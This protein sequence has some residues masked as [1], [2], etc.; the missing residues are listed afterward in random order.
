MKN[1][2]VK[3]VLPNGYKI[4]EVIN[5][6]KVYENKKFVVKE[7]KKYALADNNDPIILKDI[8]GNLVP[9][10]YFD[11]YKVD[12]EGN[13]IIGIKK[14]GKE[15]YDRVINQFDLSDTRCSSETD[16]D[17]IG[18]RVV[19]NTKH[20]SPTKKIDDIIPKEY[21]FNYGVINKEGLL[22]IYPIYDY[23]C[24]SNENTCIVG[25]LWVEEDLKYGYVDITTGDFITPIEFNE[26]RK[27]YDKRAVVGISA[28]SLKLSFGYVDRDKVITN[29]NNNNEY[30]KGL[31]PKFHN[32]TDFKDGVATVCISVPTLMSSAKYVDVDAQG[33]YINNTYRNRIKR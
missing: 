11:N 4:I 33:N 31:E 3:K 22:S 19:T 20:Y 25:N 15:V 8:N 16:Y 2:N 23:I 26:A 12:S 9:M 29:V 5:K 28:R 21:Y 24:F 32:V 17:L 1:I 27:F 18:G 14:E 13:I 6:I 10:L 30:A 7:V